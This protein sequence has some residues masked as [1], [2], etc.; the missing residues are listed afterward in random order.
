[1]IY[2]A[3]NHFLNIINEALQRFIQNFVENLYNF[4]SSLQSR[5]WVIII[6]S[7]SIQN[8]IVRRFFQ[9]LLL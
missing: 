2:V 3:V 6:L 8:T 4:L 1:M 7:I 9:I 5:L